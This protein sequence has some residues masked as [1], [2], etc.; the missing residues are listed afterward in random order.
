M[1]LLKKRLPLVQTLE[2]PLDCKEIQPVH[3]EGD[4]PWDFFG[5]NNA[6]AETPVLWP[7]HAKSW[8]IGKDFDAGR[9][10]GQEEKGKTKDEM[11]GWHHWLD[12][13]EPEWTPGVG[14]GQGGLACCDSWGRK[15][16]DTTER[17]NWTELP[18]MQETQVWSLGQKDPLEKE[19]AT[20]SSILAKKIP[21]AEEPSGLQ[22]MGLQ[23]VRRDWATNT[24][25]SL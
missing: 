15:E 18:A 23:R 11:A 12:G 19:M 24:F 3:S 22:S 2:S 9:D 16:A 10:W 17:L 4:L 1:G 21:W 20:H 5:R 7:P 14:D 25:T 6:K 8:L 13:H